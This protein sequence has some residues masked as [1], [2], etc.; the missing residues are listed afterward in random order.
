MLD[1][2]KNEIDLKQN[3]E[4]EDIGVPQPVADADEY[5]NDEDLG[6]GGYDN[7]DL[8]DGFSEDDDD[9]DLDDLDFGDDS[10]DDI[11]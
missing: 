7:G 9:E 6:Q 8:D 2:D 5:E 11:V 3:F 4:D 10:D 1:A